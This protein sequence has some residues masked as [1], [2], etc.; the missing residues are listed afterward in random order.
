MSRKAIFIEIPVFSG[1]V[2]LVSGYMEACCLKDPLLAASFT[3]EKLSLAVKTPYE[4]ILSTLQSS[5]ADVYA[6]SCYVWNTGLVRRLLSDLL[7]ARPQYHF[8]LGGPQ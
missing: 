1:V 7:K 3:F 5:N 6:F 2:P 8:I 4:Q